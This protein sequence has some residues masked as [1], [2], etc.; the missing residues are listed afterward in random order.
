M[1]PYESRFAAIF[2]T[3]YQA[4]SFW[5]GRVALYAILQSLGLRENDE[6]IVPG[7]TC[8]VVPNAI[9]Y[10]GAKP[11]YA[12][13]ADGHFN[14]DPASVRARITSRT[15]ALIAQHTYGIPADMRS[16]QA[17]AE[18]HELALIEDCAHVL[19]GSKYQNRLLGSFGIA[20]F[21]SSQW[22]KP[23]TTG[24]GGMVVTH[25]SELAE[26]LKEIQITFD[27][28]SPIQA[29]QLRIQYA[30]YRR[31]FKPRIYWYSQTALHTL[32]ELGIFLGSSN[33]TELTGKK[34]S[35]VRWRMGDFQQRV[36][37]AHIDNLEVNLSHRQTL[38]RY[39]SDTLPGHGWHFNGHFNGQE[40]ILLRFPL[41][42]KNKPLVL[43]ESSRAGIEL[44]SW[45]ETP[46]HPLPLVD[47]HLVDYRLGSCPVAESTASRVINLPLH[48]RVT[49]SDA[50][51]IVQFIL[52][53]A[54]PTPCYT[55]RLA[56][57]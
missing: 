53:T 4:F 21:F 49:P 2:G 13:I 36:G 57:G 1:H 12:D 38:S 6:V 23:Y 29:V 27:K 8:V 16:L 42:V 45:F 41:E 55:E 7:Y 31:F 20:S 3:D 51:K 39:Y 26:R 10:A 43:K 40:A 24:L 17:I 14:L 28:P 18:E 50:E 46:L 19:P 9:R 11:V 33:S 56:E 22:S 54:S 34:P 48:E 35:D 15:R 52:S 30:L 37:L 5:K 47:H 44:G 32:S 25:D